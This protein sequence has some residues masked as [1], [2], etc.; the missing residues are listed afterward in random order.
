MY[1]FLKYLNDYEHYIQNTFENTS[2]EKINK[3]NELK[4]KCAEYCK[5]HPI[6]SKD[7]HFQKHSIQRWNS[8]SLS[9]DVSKIQNFQNVIKYW[10]YFYTFHCLK[11]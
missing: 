7:I 1:S 2:I 8:F 6:S 3:I 11:K 4:K 10:K 9:S 5:T